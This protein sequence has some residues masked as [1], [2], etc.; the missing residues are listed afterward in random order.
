MVLLLFSISTL[1]TFS[2]ALLHGHAFSG[3]GAGVCRQG[4]IAGTLMHLM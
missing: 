1:F 4:R 2:F 3:A